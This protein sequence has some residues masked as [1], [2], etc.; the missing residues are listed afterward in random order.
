MIHRQ[1]SSA[2]SKSSE[3]ISQTRYDVDFI[4]RTKV[5]ENTI[6]MQERMV[7]S[8]YTNIPQEEG[9]ENNTPVDTVCKAYE[10]FYKKDTDTNPLS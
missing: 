2:Y 7:T 3:I 4:E 6:L 9:I 10:T 1:H 8:L 5:P